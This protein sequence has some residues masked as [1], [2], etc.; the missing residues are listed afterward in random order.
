MIQTKHY[1]INQKE[2]KMASL[3]EVNLIGRIGKEL[4]PHIF[5]DGTTI[6]GFSLAT[7][8]KWKDKTTQEWKEKTEWHN[9]AIH[10]PIHVEYA[11]AR[12]NKGDLIHVQGELQNR[13]WT[14]KDG[15]EGSITEVVLLPYQ[16]KLSLLQKNSEPAKVYIEPVAYDKR[17]AAL[18]QA[19]VDGK[20]DDDDV[21]F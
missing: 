10:N 7:S 14:K 21:P 20:L 8:K 4:V 6:L 16:G 18:K 3:N 17:K 9:I 19:Q 15:S 13:K 2:T 12:L 5:Q 1:L 11:T